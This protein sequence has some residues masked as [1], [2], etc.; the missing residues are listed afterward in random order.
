MTPT[1][2]VLVTTPDL[3]EFVTTDPLAVADVRYPRHAGYELRLVRGYDTRHG[4]VHGG[5]RCD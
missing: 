1:T 3:H 2:R 4:F 5:A